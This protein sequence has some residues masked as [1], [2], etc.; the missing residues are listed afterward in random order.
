M[1]GELKLGETSG[2]ELVVVEEAMG[3]IARILISIALW[4]LTSLRL[5]L[6]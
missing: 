5:P 6:N 4:V 3:L 2:N 1:R